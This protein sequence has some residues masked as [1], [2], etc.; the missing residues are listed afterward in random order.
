MELTVHMTEEELVEFLEYRKDKEV[1]QKRIKR[2]RDDLQML[3]RKMGWAVEPDP[4]KPG[5][6]KIVDQ[7]HMDD[8]WSMAGDYAE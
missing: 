3:S 4:K 8:L 2:L 1:N 6:Y 5:K 7:D